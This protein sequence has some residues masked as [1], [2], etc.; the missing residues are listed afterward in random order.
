MDQATALERSPQAGFSE[1]I[2]QAPQQQGLTPTVVPLDRE[3]LTFYG[4]MITAANLV[5]QESGVTP[6]IS[7]YRVMAK[8][9]AGV[10]Y[11]FDPVL[12]Q[13]CFDVLFNRMTPNAHGM[14]ILF[15]D[16]GEYDTRIKQLD[17]EACV[18]T[19]IKQEGGTWNESRGRFEGG[20][21]RVLGEASKGELSTLH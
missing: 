14:E 20:T 10:S 8:I 21:W 7:K 12:S 9:V 11:G 17:D 18:I 13:S 2:Q 1:M 5:P 15:R 4:N 3:T 16:S 6:E 19:V